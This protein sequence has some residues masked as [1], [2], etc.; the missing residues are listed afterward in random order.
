MDDFPQDE[1][2]DPSFDITPSSSALAALSCLNP[3][4]P[5]L[6]PSQLTFTWSSGDIP[7]VL[8]DDA[9]AI[10]E[11]TLTTNISLRNR[12]SGAF[13]N[14]AG[15]RTPDFFKRTQVP[16]NRISHAGSQSDID[17]FHTSESSNT[18]ASVGTFG[19]RQRADLKLHS[20]ETVFSEISS[21]RTVDCEWRGTTMH[22]A[23]E[24][25]GKVLHDTA[26]PVA[27][28]SQT[29]SET[30]KDLAP[31]ASLSGNDKI[32]EFPPLR[33]ELDDIS[34]WEHAAYELPETPS[35]VSDRIVSWVH[36]QEWKSPQKQDYGFPEIV[37]YDE[38]QTLTSPEAVSPS[39]RGILVER[40][41]NHITVAVPS[42]PRIRHEHQRH[43]S[44]HQLDTSHTK[45]FHPPKEDFAWIED[46][47]VQCLIDQEGFRTA[48]PSF[49]LSGIVHPRSPLEPQTPGP[50]MAQ[51]RPITRQYFH[52]HHAAFETSPILRRVTIN[53]QETHDYVSRQAL[54]TLKC[55]G[56]YVVHGHE[57]SSVEHNGQ[58]NLKLSWQF[59]YLVDDRRVDISGRV[60]EGEKVLTPLTFSCSPELLLPAQGKRI[61]I[62]HVLKKSVAPKLS[63]EKLQPPGSL[64]G[65]RLGSPDTLSPGKTSTCVSHPLFGGNLHRRVQSHGTHQQDGH[66]AAKDRS[67]T[68]NGTDDNIIHHHIRTAVVESANVHKDEFGGHRRRA[69]SASDHS[70]AASYSSIILRNFRRRDDSPIKVAVAPSPHP[71]RH[72]IPPSRLAEL[73]DTAE[74]YPASTTCCDQSTFTSL[75]PRP[76]SRHAF[77]GKSEDFLQGG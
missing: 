40:D 36:S 25:R 57:M 31:G 77:R 56:V 1:L 54:L 10:N 49:K 68:H 28:T 7:V 16:S 37:D 26:V 38:K 73:F 71:S 23:R 24:S 59:E 17:F 29:S 65:G 61:S 20:D 66:K 13:S 2:G 48:Q 21:P 52:F 15:I 34:T 58:G 63:A 9:Y 35:K 74:I 76:R 53:D 12:D 44:N 45:H 5:I 19:P 46:I 32:I 3:P 18:L 43:K 22:H 70:Q 4:S 60:M 55:N 69:C 47:T 41:I 51:F 67:R 39:R 75:A 8:F 11:P 27:L 14:G 33:T 62:M 50:A 30:L 72:I 6:T 64:N 42:P